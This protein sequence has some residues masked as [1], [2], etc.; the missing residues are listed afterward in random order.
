LHRQAAFEGLNRSTKPKEV[1]NMDE[2]MKKGIG[3]FRFGVIHDL[4]GGRRLSRGEK[5]RLIR[6]KSC[7][8]WEIPYCG[9]SRISGSTILNWVRRYE[10]SGGRLE[11][12]Y[13]DDRE[14]KGKFRV[15]DEDTILALIN[16]KKQLKDAPVPVLLREA[17]NR[18]ILPVDFN[19][20]LATMYRLY[21]RYELMQPQTKQEDMRRFEAELPNDIWQS[22][23]MHGCKV[24][25]DGRLRKSYLFGIIDD[26]SRLIPN[27]RFY[28]KEN[29][30]S[31]RDCLIKALNKRGLPRKLYV[32][33][34]PTF[35]SVQLGYAT[36]S[37]GIA[38]VHAKPY[39]PEGKGKIERWFHTVRTSFLSTISDGLTI[40][41]LNKKLD[42]WIDTHY[43]PAI[44]S[45]TNQT[46]L[47]RY[48][49]HIHLIRQAPKD[50][51]DY[52]RVRVSRR[53][54]KDRTVS[55]N[56]MVYEAPVELIGKQVALLYN[57][58]DP[59]RIQI[60]YN[61][62]SYGMLV[63]LDPHINCRI[64]RNQSITQIV[65]PDDTGKPVVEPY[66]AGKLFGG[67]NNGK[68]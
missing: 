15:L 10:N 68:L 3:E 61:N 37:L 50:L 32:D 30:G 27:A 16:L 31:F 60:M 53:V 44:H 35:R 38:L 62:K 57:E 48:I 49:K 8:E 59:S 54:D 14:D 66:K 19:I 7:C 9:R 5:Q 20:S 42:D 2:D 21:N 52:F 36:A 6:D 39:R 23:C 63:P 65:S 29:I 58:N 34:G 43:H 4:I 26:H 51:E 13:P 22:D 40:D 24:D 17:R 1:K 46:P 33:N 12:L 11:S 45:S 47:E 56:G 64:R 41:Q 67:E 28:L 25:V 55:I 18:K